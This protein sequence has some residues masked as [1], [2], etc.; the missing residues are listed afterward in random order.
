MSTYLIPAD[1]W[2]FT[3]QIFVFDAD[4]EE[5]R[6]DSWTWTK[7]AIESGAEV[8]DFAVRQPREYSLSGIVT[9]WSAGS[10]EEVWTRLTD[11]HARLV[12][13]A[14]T[15]QPVTMVCGTWLDDVVITKVSAKKS[16]DTGEALEITISLQSYEI[17]EYETVEIPSDLL[18]PKVKASAQTAKDGGAGAAETSPET[19]EGEPPWDPETETREHALARGAPGCAAD[20]P[21]VNNALGSI[22]GSS[23]VEVQ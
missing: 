22:Y 21:I 13:F 16:T 7:Y 10:D 8:S 5:S 2:D 1:S 6:D 11:V 17:A 20:I 4:T 19:D 12:D 18:A 9:A 14:N 15:K 23:E 3:D